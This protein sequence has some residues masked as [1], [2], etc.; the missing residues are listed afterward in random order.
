MAALPGHYRY[1]FE[2]KFKTL[3]SL[4]SGHGIELGF[5]YGCRIIGLTLENLNWQKCANGDF[6]KNNLSYATKKHCF[7]EILQLNR[8]C[9]GPPM[10]RN[11]LGKAGV[12]YKKLGW[13]A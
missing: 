11:E 10:F 7:G 1:I 4:P 8:R 2:G 6:S 3:R 5:F 13:I 9:L 12:A